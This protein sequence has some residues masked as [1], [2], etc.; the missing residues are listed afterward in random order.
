MKKLIE[1]D[2]YKELIKNPKPY[3]IPYLVEW[4]DVVTYKNKKKMLE[5]L[6][7]DYLLKKELILMYCEDFKYDKNDFE[8]LN[9]FEKE[10]NCR[11][12]NKQVR[13]EFMNIIPDATLKEQ[14]DKIANDPNFIRFLV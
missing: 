1:S 12:G 10:L 7:V 2:F 6:M 13:M 4:G 14:F 5:E 11:I 9:I 8:Q 3:T